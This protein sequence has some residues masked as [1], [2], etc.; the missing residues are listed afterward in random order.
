[1]QHW[2]S[3]RGVQL[4][5]FPVQERLSVGQMQRKVDHQV[6]GYEYIRGRI[7]AAL[8]R[9]PAKSGDHFSVQFFVPSYWRGPETGT[10]KRS[11]VFQNIRNCLL[12]FVSPMRSKTAALWRWRSYLQSRDAPGRPQVLINLDET[13]V[14][15]VPQERDGHVS[16]RAYRHRPDQNFEYNSN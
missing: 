15:L 2:R 14:K 16:K 8:T 5:K 9:H 3:R 1:M 11:S 10:R 6:D 12:K 4:R 7:A 13:N